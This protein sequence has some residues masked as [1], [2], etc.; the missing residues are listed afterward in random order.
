MCPWQYTYLKYFY[1]YFLSAHKLHSLKMNCGQEF[2]CLFL[3]TCGSPTFFFF[4]RDAMCQVNLSGGGGQI[5]E[6]ALRD[7]GG[8]L[9]IGFRK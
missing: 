5:I 7:I 6:S 4:F 1:Y 2:T 3:A 8:N 9:R